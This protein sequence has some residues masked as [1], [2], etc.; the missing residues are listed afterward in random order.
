MEVQR[1]QS[2]LE[3]FRRLRGWSQAELANR[4]QTSRAAVSAIE[5][6]RHVPS[7]EVALSLAR[8][9]ECKVED[10]FQLGGTKQEPVWAWPPKR[11]PCRFFHSSVLGRTVLY[12]AEETF[13]GAPP[14][15]GVFTG[16]RQDLRSSVE[17]DQTLVVAGCDAAI[18]LLSS[19]LERL[20]GFRLLIITRSSR[21][22]LELLR[23]RLVHVAGVHL[24]DPESRGGNARIVQNALGGGYCLLRHARWQEGVALDPTLKIN[25]VRKALQSN[26]RWIGREEGT[27]ARRCF[28]RLFLESRPRKSLSS[29]TANS[30]LAV[31]EAIKSGWAQAGVCPRLF[32][33]EA[34]LSFL[35]VEREDYDLC[36]P[37]ELEGD[38]RLVA[39]VKAVRS[40][41]YRQMLGDLEGYDT[42]STGEIQTVS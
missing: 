22:A 32:A 34:R 17:P 7:T 35:N 13:L 14:H 28:D 41:S 31:V 20:S 23:Q 6:G 39:L 21:E 19:E 10:L 27:G 26:L 16:K 30:H 18:R 2:S 15:D 36:Y 25:S 12:P 40:S 5:T 38:P 3:S 24:A 1:F 42:A 8:A 4:A 33:L 9:F 37:V 11:T 29:Y